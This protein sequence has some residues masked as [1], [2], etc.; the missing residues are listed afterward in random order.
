MSGR[1]RERVASAWASLENR[2]LLI[3]LLI[4]TLLRLVA[5]LYLGDKVELIPV[6]YDQIHFDN[7]AHSLL[8]GR[9]FS[10]T[11]PPWP[12]IQA[13]APTAFVSFLYTLFVASVYW[14]FGPHALVARVIQAL[15]CSL[16][17]W[18]VYGLVR[19]LMA[20]GRWPQSVAD[21]RWP[22][23]EAV[24]LVAAAI[25]AGYAYFVFYSATLMTEGFYL[26]TVVW[27]LSLTLDLAEAPSA[28][29]WASWGLAV[30]LASL[31]RQVFM[32]LAA[33]LFLYILWQARRRVKIGH[34][35][36]AG[37]IAAL[38][39]LPWTVRNYLVFDRFL[40]LNSQTGQILWN[41]NHPA[42][43]TDFD[44]IAMFPIPAELE[45]LNEAELDSALL[46]LGL[47]NV[48]ADPRR[49]VGLSLSRLAA[50]FRFWPIPSSS[51]FNNVARTASFAI[52]LPFMVAGLLLSRREPRRWLLL[53]L[54]IAAYTFIHAISWAGIRYRLPVDVALVPFAALAVVALLAR[55]GFRTTKTPRV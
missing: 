30:S 50:F 52:C 11:V 37:G 7:V 13:G 42:M 36:L 54:F 1:V 12:F 41:A 20:N 4:G 27:A 55:W 9:G 49:F 39:I 10:F 45:G 35:A 38:L 23:A 25:T 51:T 46:R 48:A 3:I 43:G 26:V 17:P 6:A 29:R 34:V 24:A 44:S 8:A 5:A 22:M 47:Q 2:W 21:S 16:L 15:V 53:Y 40:L 32:P 14:L 19:R 33:L 31:L 18:Q 28:P